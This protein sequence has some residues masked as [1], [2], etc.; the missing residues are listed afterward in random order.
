MVI[1]CTLV[2]NIQH[3]PIPLKLLD[4][5]SFPKVSNE[6]WL[7][8]A[9]KQL[10][11]KDPFEELKWHSSGMD[12]LKPYYDETAIDDLVDQMEFFQGLPPHEWKLFEKVEVKEESAANQQAL[13][14]LIGGCDGIFFE[15]QGKVDF[16]KLLKGID[17]SICFISSDQL[18]EGASG[19]N[20]T[21]SLIETTTNS[22]AEQVSGIL[23]EIK[24]SHQWVRRVAF[25]DFCAEIAT[26]RALRYLLNTKR[27]GGHVAIHTSIPM[28]PEEDHQWF[29]NTT[30]GLASILGGSFSVSFETATGDSRISRNVG[31]IIREESGISTYED[32]CGGSFY[33][34]SLTHR[35]IEQ[36]K[37]AIT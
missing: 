27:S 23:A 29:L 4:L 5:S 36:V 3:K 21:N 13:A 16:S 14:A 22:S 30:A 7:L 35:I 32:Q 11:G 9:Q 2:P 12:D 26:V 24:D 33:I 10:K 8:E 15:S 37:R 1:L 34:E 20:S 25:P 19:I 17:L 6:E 18:I 31:N 28:H